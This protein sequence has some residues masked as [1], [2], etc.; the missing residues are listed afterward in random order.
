MEYVFL[1]KFRLGYL[2]HDGPISQMARYRCY[3]RM[4]A[5]LENGALVLKK[6]L[7]ILVQT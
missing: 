6:Y 5:N 2:V 1:T 7:N 4:P 3:L